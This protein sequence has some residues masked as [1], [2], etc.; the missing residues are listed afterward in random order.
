MLLVVVLALRVHDMSGSAIAV[1]ALFAA[2]MLPVVL[3]APLAGRLVDGFE[4]R[5]VL[6]VVSLAQLVVA[7]GLVFADSVAAIL[8]LTALVGAGAAVAGPAEAALIPAVARG[9]DLARANGWVE[10]CALRRLHRGSADRGGLTAAGGTRLGL[11]ANAR[12]FAAVA[13]A[14]ATMRA[15]RPPQ[16]QMKTDVGRDGLRL[17]LDDP[18]LRPTLGAA[19]GALLFI[20][21]VMTAEVF[22]VRTWWA[23]ARRATHSSMRGGWPEWSWARSASPRG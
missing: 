12:R 3:L 4:T 2:L 1:A 13:L 18:V 15:R 20:S 6:L 16:P 22:Y 9:T 11:A 21:A 8:A 5:R 14:A 10:T 19:V 7:G 17:L 23:R